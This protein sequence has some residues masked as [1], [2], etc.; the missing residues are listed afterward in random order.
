VSCTII[1]GDNL[2]NDIT[3]RRRQPQPLK[4]LSLR[5]G[6]LGAELLRGAI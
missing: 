1:A 5:T 2:L 3:K 4:V 6:L